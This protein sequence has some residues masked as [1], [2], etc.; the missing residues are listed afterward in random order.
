MTLS[1]TKRA[2]VD[3]G[4]SLLAGPQDEVAAIALL[5]GA[6][7]SR[8]GVYMI[9]CAQSPS[10]SFALGGREYTLQGSDLVVGKSD[11]NCLLG[12]QG[13]DM[14]LWILGDV[15]MRKYYVLFDWGQR[16]LGFAAA[17]AATNLV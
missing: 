1:K 5:L 7:R 17:T 6:T 15:F 11:G 13:L 16:R 9:P 14:P 12:L 8:E 10:I 3:S 4:T 2:I